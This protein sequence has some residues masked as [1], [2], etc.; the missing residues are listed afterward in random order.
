MN[1]KW[2]IAALALLWPALAASGQDVGK[3]AAF[4]VEC[5]GAFRAVHSPVVEDGKLRKNQ[6]LYFDPANE[7]TDS[8]LHLVQYGLEG[9]LVGLVMPQNG[10]R[11]A[12]SILYDGGKP[13]GYYKDNRLLGT[14][15]T[16]YSPF[17]FCLATSCYNTVEQPG[18]VC[19]SV[20]Y[21]YDF[22]TRRITIA[23]SPFGGGE[24]R[25]LDAGIT[26]YLKD[27]VEQ[28]KTE[29]AVAGGIAEIK[30]SVRKDQEYQL[31]YTLRYSV[32]PGAGN[33]SFEVIE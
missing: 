5:V 16:P 6:V 26:V 2:A 7:F 9:K 17:G 3:G 28:G 23:A 10:S 1:R 22:G 32:D 27:G 30:I 29:K 4:S 33:F 19:L 25:I 24:R 20:S 8:E 18:K 15:F 11:V 13:N 21:F 31:V 12:Y 14:D